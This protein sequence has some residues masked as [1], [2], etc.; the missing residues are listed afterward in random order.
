MASTPPSRV[1][2]LATA[3]PFGI[4]LADEDEFSKRL[5]AMELSA[6]RTNAAVLANKVDSL[7][8]MM[9]QLHVTTR[10]NNAILNQ[11]LFSL[12]ERINA[13]IDLVREELVDLINSKL[14]F[15]HV[16]PSST[17]ENPRPKSV[18]P[19]KPP[20][21]R[22][23]LMKIFEGIESMNPDTSTA[24]SVSY[25]SYKVKPIPGFVIKTR[26]LLGNKDKVFINVFHHESI[27]LEPLSPLP[28]SNADNRPYLVIG[29]SSNALDKDGH[30]CSIFNVAVS[31][32][33]FKPDSKLDFKIT[34][35]NS[36]QKV[37][38]VR[39]LNSLQWSMTSLDR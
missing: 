4:G 33:Y 1:N 30:N 14:N 9:Q 24:A 21:R 25:E 12:E 35:P 6:D 3:L 29:E 31:S 13:R 28:K 26:K 7:V 22:P 15:S 23:T 11:M 10:D 34:A 2:N 17:F 36:I 18:A 39:F 32:E 27:D 38:A 37:C 16:T 5:E 8:G 19:E 20:A